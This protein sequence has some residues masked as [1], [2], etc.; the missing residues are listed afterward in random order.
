MA[1]PIRRE[2][3]NIDDAKGNY[4]LSFLIPPIEGSEWKGGLL[5]I[6]I[7]QYFVRLPF[8]WNEKEKDFEIL[9]PKLVKNQAAILRKIL[10]D[11]NYSQ[12]V[13]C[14]FDI[15]KRKNSE[16]PTKKQ[17]T[18]QERRES[19]RKLWRDRYDSIGKDFFFP[20][21]VLRL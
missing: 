2:F 18:W 12:P 1:Y 10:I 16:E 14:L 17:K 21:W 19:A 6:P 13:S 7:A 15:S 3:G 5:Q 11:S 8:I 20:D 9:D 4:H